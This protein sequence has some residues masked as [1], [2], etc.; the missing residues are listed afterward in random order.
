[1]IL[2]IGNKGLTLIEVLLAVSIL[3]FGIIGVLRA[4]AV[5][6]A[7][8]EIGQYNI[9]AVSLMKQK[10]V[11]TEK[12]IL[13]MAL[14]EEKIPQG[15]E[16]GEFEKP[17]EDF[18]WEREISSTET[19]GLSELTLVISHKYNPRTFSLTTYVVDREE[20]EDDEDDED[21]EG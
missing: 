17:F 11:D 14:E 10:M 21:G 4:Y 15:G 12:M 2:R 3:A 13:E 5:S 1:M 8:L 18:L 6:I 20:E 16:H 19:E 7:T 9:D